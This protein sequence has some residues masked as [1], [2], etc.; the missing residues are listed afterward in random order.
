MDITVWNSCYRTKPNRR[1]VYALM[2][3]IRKFGMLIDMRVIE[4]KWN[5]KIWLVDEEEVPVRWH[6]IQP[7]LISKYRKVEV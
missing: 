2:V 7:G 4:T 6:Y 3:G 1:G 5:G